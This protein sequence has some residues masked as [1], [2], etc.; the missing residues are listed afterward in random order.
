MGLPDSSQP[1]TM[2]IVGVMMAKRWLEAHAKENSRQETRTK[3]QLQ[4]L[5]CL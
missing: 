2:V 4:E 3:E 1:I 5:D